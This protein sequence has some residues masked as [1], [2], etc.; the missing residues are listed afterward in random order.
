[1]LRLDLD[2]GFGCSKDSL[3]PDTIYLNTPDTGTV[4]AKLLWCVLCYSSDIE[5]GVTIRVLGISTIDLYMTFFSWMD[6]IILK[7]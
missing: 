2:Y 7:K 5:S 4:T 1:M 3:T 6:Q